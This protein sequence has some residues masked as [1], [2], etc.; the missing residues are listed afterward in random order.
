MFNT[1]TFLKRYEFVMQSNLASFSLSA[2]DQISPPHS[3]K[4]LQS[5]DLVTDSF[6]VHS[7]QIPFENHIKGCVRE[8]KLQGC[9]SGNCRDFLTFSKKLPTIV[10]TILLSVLGN[11]IGTIGNFKNKKPQKVV[12]YLKLEEI[13]PYE[14]YNFVSC[15]SRLVS[16]LNEDSSLQETWAK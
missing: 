9:I 13:Q 11:V 15:F 16:L 5:S 7:L 14:N 2:F 8:R 4:T 12:A 10:N 6:V 3:T 1:K